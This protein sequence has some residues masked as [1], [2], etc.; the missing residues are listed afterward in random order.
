MKAAVVHSF[1]APPRYE[2]FEDPVPSAREQLVTVTAAGLH[3]VVKALASG[4]HYGNT[5]KPPFIAGIDGV[6]RLPDGSRV[7]FGA[8]RGSFAEK[9][10][11]GFT[12]PLPDA[13]DDV[14]AAGIAN[15]GMSS[16]AALKL[17]AHL[18]AGERVLILGATGIAGRLAIQIARR[19][20]ARRVIAAGRNIERVEDLGADALISLDKEHDFIQEPFDA[21]LDY[22][23]GKPAEDLIASLSQKGFQHTSSRVRFIQVGSSAGAQISLPAEALRS[24]G[25]EMMG[26]GFGSV[27]LEL[28]LESV[29]EFLAEAAREPF[30]F[31]AR[32]VPLRAVEAFWNSEDRVVFQP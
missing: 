31:H 18:A 10:L 5:S 24:S 1:D 21:V 12:W 27:P 23:W 17:R 26:S 16:W 15:P 25:L 20:G 13:L 30:Q 9:A 7:Y 29:T 22:L 4:T 19:L 14:T 3:R 2:T 8:S 6:G 32:P 11:A 28:I